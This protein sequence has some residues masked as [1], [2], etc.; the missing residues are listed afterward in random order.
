MS[1][2]GVQ[3]PAYTTG[4]PYEHLYIGYLM[5]RGAVALLA[6]FIVRETA[7]VELSEIDARFTHDHAVGSELLTNRN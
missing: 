1:R 5:A 4:T 3:V 2:L 6:G 7:G